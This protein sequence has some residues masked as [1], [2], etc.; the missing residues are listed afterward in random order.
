[1]SV[2]DAGPSLGLVIRIG[3]SSAEGAD[4]AEPS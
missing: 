1:V 4:G 2:P 3:A